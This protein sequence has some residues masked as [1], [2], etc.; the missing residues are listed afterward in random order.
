MAQAISD[1]GAYMSADDHRM[2]M[3]ELLDLPVSFGL[4][5]AARALGIGR[6]KAYDLVAAGEFPLPVKK[7]GREYRVTRPD[8]FRYFGLQP[9]R[10][11]TEVQAKPT[12]DAA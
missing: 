10:V 4:P 9:D 8:L 6:T 7:Y 1:P 2:T 5:V 12:A 11:A 3:E